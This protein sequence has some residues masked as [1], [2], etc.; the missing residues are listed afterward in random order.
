MAMSAALGY[1]RS[2]AQGQ[3]AI[4]SLNITSPRSGTGVSRA[5]VQ[6]L[7]CCGQTTGGGD[8]RFRLSSATSIFSLFTNKL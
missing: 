2:D 5:F 3:D 7:G 4:G 6:A 8:P 1:V